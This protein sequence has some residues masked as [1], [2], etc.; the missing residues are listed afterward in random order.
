MN[1]DLNC[2]PYYDADTESRDRISFF[3]EASIKEEI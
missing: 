3:A 1:C 2:F